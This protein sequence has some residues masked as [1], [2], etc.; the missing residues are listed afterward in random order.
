MNR[1]VVILVLLISSIVTDAQKFDKTFYLLG[2]L[3]D[4]GGRRVQSMQW[5]FISSLHQSRMGEIK[6]IKEITNVKSTRRT[7]KKNC[8]NCHEFYNLHSFFRARKI[9]KFYDF[10]KDK[11]TK[12]YVGTLNCDKVSDAKRNNQISFVAGLFLMAGEKKD[13]V[14]KISLYNSPE[15]YDCIYYIF[16]KKLDCEILSAIEKEGLPYGYFIEFKP[17]EELKK[18]LDNEIE[19]KKTF[20]SSKN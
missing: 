18:I 2:T 19:K 5:G 15:K 3:E 8:K 20:T 9:N 17:T 4:Y 6:R 12:G 16:L 14:Y 7:K 1:T 10:E 13:D 11:F